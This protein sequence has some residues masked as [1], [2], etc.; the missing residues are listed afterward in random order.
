MT[1]TS[2]SS[3]DISHTSITDKLLTELSY[4]LLLISKLKINNCLLLTRDFL[5]AVLKF[6]RLITCSL[7]GLTKNIP[8]LETI[9]KNLENSVKFQYKLKSKLDEEEEN[10]FYNDYYDDY[11]YH[12]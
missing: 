6:P 2:L 7:K 9:L 4:K 10:N 3:L 5:Y 8:L 1:L 11:C 12:D